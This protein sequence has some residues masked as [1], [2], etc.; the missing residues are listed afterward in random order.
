[1][2]KVGIP[3]NLLA[4]LVPSLAGRSSRGERKGSKERLSFRALLAKVDEAEEPETDARAEAAGIGAGPASLDSNRTVEVMLDDVH[5][6][7]EA[8]SKNPSP[9]AIVA[10]KDAVRAFV[11]HVVDKV[12]AVEERTSGGNILKRKKYT[13]LSIIDARLERLAADIMAGQRDKLEILRK[14]DE[15]AGLLVDLLS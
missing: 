9:D 2:E 10:Y 15:I 12:Y 8:L 13:A 4:G 3:D 7:G 14:V 6:L 1:M 11:K 5:R